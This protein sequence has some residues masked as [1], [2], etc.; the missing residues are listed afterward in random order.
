MK[1]K[2]PRIIP[3][4]IHIKAAK[5]IVEN[6][7]LDKPKTSGE[8]LASVGYSK[9]VTETPSRVLESPSFKQALRDLGLTEELITTSLVSDIKEKAKN[10]LG[11]LRL[12]AEILGLN[13]PENEPEKPKQSNTYNFFFSKDVQKE[14]KNMED[15]IESILIQKHVQEN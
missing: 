10:R 15:K 5:A 9:G 13:K 1:A 8:V 12:G 2:S 14:I 11:E 3:R 4:P 6:M 7:K